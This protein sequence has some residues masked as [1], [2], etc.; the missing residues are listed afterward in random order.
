M[1]HTAHHP[2]ALQGNLLD[3]TELI[4]ILAVTKQTAQVGGGAGCVAGSSGG[5]ARWA[6]EQSCHMRARARTDAHCLPAC[7]PARLVTRR[8]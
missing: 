4:D 3:D 6:G 8:R 5:G 1:L 2:I 7:L